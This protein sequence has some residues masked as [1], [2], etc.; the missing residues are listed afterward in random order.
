MADLR[1]EY[2]VAPLGI[3]TTKPRFSWSILS[4]RRGDRQTAYRLLVASSLERLSED[5]GDVWDSG[6]T[7]SSQSVFVEYAGTPLAADSEYFWKVRAWNKDGVQSGWSTACRFTVGLL[8]KADWKAQWI[9][10]ASANDHDEP[11]IRKRFS[12]DGKPSRALI[13]VGS[14]GYHEL[15]VNGK[16]VG[17]R[18]LS[19]S[20]SYLAK[21]ALYVTYDVAEYLV[22]GENVVG[23]WL[24]PGWSLFRGVNPVMDFGLSKKP[25]A[26]AQL[27]IRFA[28]GN[29][30]VI[31]SNADWKCRLSNEKHLGEWTNSNFGG[32]RVDGSLA[33][34]NWNGL[35]LDDSSWERATTYDVRQKLSPDLV[36]PNR[37]CEAFQPIEIIAAGPRVYKVD[38]GKLFTGWMEVQLKGKPGETVVLSA[39]TE[40]NTECELN[41]RNEYVLGPEG[42]GTFCNRF[43]YHEYRYLTISGLDSPPSKKD[44]VGYR[45]GNAFRRVGS[46]DCSNPLIKK[47]YDA[48]INN[49]LNLTTG[50]MMVD[51]PHRERLGYG[52]DAHTSLGTMLNNMDTN[53]FYA[54]WARDWCDI[55]QRDGYIAHTAP[56]IDGGGGTAWSGFVVLMPWEVYLN[57]GDRRILETSYPHMKRWLAF[58]DMKCNAD[59]LL[60]PY[61]GSWGFLGDWLT[62]HGIEGSETTAALL[63]NNC[64]RIL[65]TRTAAKVA[66]E[67]GKTKDAK[68][69]EKQA[70]IAVHAVN[71]RFFNAQKNTYLDERQTHYV[72]PLIA[73]VVPKDHME[74]VIE[75]LRREILVT[76]RGHLDTGLH[77]THFMTKYLIENDGNDLVFAYASQT[78]NPGYGYFLGQGLNSWP[79]EWGKVAGASKLHGSYNGIGGWFL[80]GIGGIRPE[81]GHRGFQR[82]VIKPAIVG[83]LTWAKTAYDSNY[84]K[85]ISNWKRDDKTLEMELVIPANT[86]AT[87]FVSTKDVSTIT[88]GG[89]PIASAE[90]V[91]FLCASGRTAMFE[92]GA[93]KYSIASQIG[94]TGRPD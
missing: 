76:H 71:K 20:V 78:T 81:A 27:S 37:K 47:I 68:R 23:I 2:S 93:G 41:Q 44:V 58:L 26:I 80:Q 82:F 33:M 57:Y 90:G 39:S 61:G 51:C 56:T 6:K 88:E 86:T 40:K 94:P 89:K 15:Y 17:D 83:D 12:L 18:V 52:G 46:F 92:I 72:M 85:I 28:N 50:G 69:W 22:P 14:I 3:N 32:D 87:V 31:T 38:M 64:Y 7:D 63:F 91:R 13:Y 4:D 59:G 16:R 55:Q 5:K 74:S 70:E 11:W 21:R 53:V 8:S 54:K 66:R 77:G 24:G 48:T 65:V 30:A 19:P 43:A 73:G 45:I 62:P 10:M 42:R 75:N 1:C 49:C 60:M 79:E 9:G 29:A 25:L 36:A 84:G 35:N 67:L 34:P